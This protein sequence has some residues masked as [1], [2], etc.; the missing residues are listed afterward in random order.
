MIVLWWTTAH[1][2]EYYFRLLLIKCQFT[3]SC[4]VSSLV[5]QVARYSPLNT[6]PPSLP[7]HYKNFNNTTEKSATDWDFDTFCLTCHAS[8]AFSLDILN[9]LLTF[10][11]V[12]RKPLVMRNS[13][14]IRTQ[15]VFAYVDASGECLSSFGVS[16]AGEGR[17]STFTS[18]IFSRVS[19]YHL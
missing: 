8:L 6:F 15:E 7:S 18:T 5:Y 14:S 10:H 17:P 13:T 12:R 1:F 9:L 2:A 11:Q 19:L 3:F 4:I 16:G